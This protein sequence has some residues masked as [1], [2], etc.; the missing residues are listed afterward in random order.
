MTNEN[1]NELVTL[2][3]LYSFQNKI[4]SSI[5]TLITKQNQKEFYTPKEFSKVTGMK[6]S[7]IIYYLNRGEIKARQKG[8]KSAWLIHHSEIERF[9]K[10]ADSNV[11]ILPLHE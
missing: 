1:L 10:E 5:K 7:T 8:T 4:L 3:D 9:I 2:G 11:K 6:Y